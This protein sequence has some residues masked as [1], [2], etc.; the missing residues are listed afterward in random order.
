MDLDGDLGP[1][2]EGPLGL[3]ASILYGFEDTGPHQIAVILERGGERYRADRTVVVNDGAATRVVAT[4]SASG[5]GWTE[6]IAY[7]PGDGTIYVLDR[8]SRRLVRLHGATLEALDE[9]RLPGTGW[10]EGMAVDVDRDVAYVLVPDGIAAYSLADSIAFRG[11]ALLEEEMYGTLTVGPDGALYHVAR[12]RIRRIDPDLGEVRAESAA[13]TGPVAF[14]LAGERLVHAAAFG[15]I[16]SV[17]DPGTLGS[18]Q[19]FEVP[20]DLP[21]PVAAAFHPAGDHLYVLLGRGEWHL[22]VIRLADLEIVR[23]VVLG[24]DTNRFSSYDPGRSSPAAVSFDGRFVVFS[25]G[26][27]AF[28]VRTSDHLALYRTMD[29][30]VDPGDFTPENPI[31]C[32]NVAASPTSPVFWFSNR[33]EGRVTRVEFLR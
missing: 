31:G 15:R 26:L 17:L 13:G 24:Q 28:F 6:E 22:L 1:D 4:G 19:H 20:E 9:E 32:C 3:G 18:I 16:V 23:D 33:S 29:P 12:G 10:A 30:P 14:D 7:D 11:M 21:P 2:E 27:G 5:S 25:T 8:Q